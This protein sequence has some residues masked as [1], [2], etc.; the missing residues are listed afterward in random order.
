MLIAGPFTIASMYAFSLVIGYLNTHYLPAPIAPSLPK[1]LGM[2]WAVVLWGWFT[3]EQLS[4]L[5]L[6]RTGASPEAIGQITMSPVRVALYGFWILTLLW[7]LVAV[8]RRKG[9]DG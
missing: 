2:A 4:R 5:I 8:V 7:F 6:S 1:R 3:V 9:R